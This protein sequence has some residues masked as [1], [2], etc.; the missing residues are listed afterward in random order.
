[1]KRM[2]HLFIS[3]LFLMAVTLSVAAQT[4]AFTYQG[5]LS[6]SGSPATGNYDFVFRLYGAPNGG[7]QVGTAFSTNSVP[8][9]NG[10]FTVTLDFGSIQFAGANRWLEISVSTN[11]VELFS[12]LTA[13]QPITSTPYAIRALSAGSVPSGAI[14]ST[15]LANGSV[16]SSKLAP[17]AVSF[18]DASDGSPT[19][20]VVVNAAGLVGIGTNDPR[21]AL[22]ISATAPIFTGRRLFQVQDENGGYLNL[23]GESSI[24]T[25]GKLLAASGAS[26]NGI[27]IVDVSNPASPIL[28]AQPRDGSGSFTN[29]AYVVGLAMKTNLLAAAAFG[30]NAVTVVSLTNPASPVRLAELRDGVGGWNEL[31]GATAVAISGNLMAIGAYHDSAVTLADISNP[32]APVKRIEMKD[33]L[34]GFTGLSNVY[35]LAFSGNLLAIAAI[36]ESAVTLVD[37]SD[38]ANP[39]KLAE[40]RDDVG[41]YTNLRG[42]RAVAFSGSLLA[43][44]AGNDDAVTLVNVANPASPVK[45][46]ELRRG[47][48]DLDWL[49]TPTSAALLGN[50]LAVGA[51][52]GHAAGLFDISSP[53]APRLLTVIRDNVAGFNYLDQIFAIAF[54]GSNLAIRAENALT[55]VS[56][57]SAGAALVS[58]G[59]VGIGTDSPVAPLS[60][61]GDVVVQNAQLFDINAD[62]FEFGVGCAATAGG[63]SAIGVN[64]NATGNSSTAIGSRATATGSSA[65]AIGMNARA[66]DSQ[67]T[68]I[69]AFAMA[70]G[71]GSM[72]L[73]DSTTASGD[74]STAMGLSSEAT[75]FLSTALGDNTTAS[76]DYSTAM[77]SSSIASGDY[78]TAMG[79]SG[80]ATNDGTFV[81]ADAT[82]IVITSTNNHSV[83]M[84]ASGGYRLFSNPAASAGVFLASNGVAWAALSDRNAKKNFQSL[85]SKE[86]LEKLVALPVQRWNYKWEADNE[87]PHIGPVAQDFKA[88]FYPGRDQTHITTLEFD[89]VALAAIQG[90][91]QKVEE[92][93]VQLK[94]KDGDLQKL[95]R[96]NENLEQRLQKLEALLQPRR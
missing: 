17:G 16:T 72:A 64:A 30:D 65:V 61:A 58:Q 52:G 69:G 60:V 22:D 95:Q 57:P 13:R 73:G 47:D 38:P 23:L 82:G 84:R 91:N 86:I 46:A 25:F 77:G 66:T 53:S 28:L 11:G 87:V 33:G 80:R 83:T 5:H 76:G 90:L 40:L 78:S 15:M 3:V 74:Y 34:F 93:R 18:L 21:A 14:T 32:L 59:W 79:R 50:W 1:M 26:D 42:A 51:F 85:K 70:S 92:Q 4:T 67:S 20:A 36:G 10:L 43:I 88:A 62:R 75:G 54:A 49:D 39:L 56:F 2:S 24:A 6:D 94:R 41:G 96:H 27:T 31:D 89:G 9:S 48:P 55:V 7:G 8:L 71:F 44:A 35:G 29:L 63:S 12:T 81:W 37:V 68:A 45:L 19:N